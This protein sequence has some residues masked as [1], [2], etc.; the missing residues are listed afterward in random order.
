VK[1]KKYISGKAINKLMNDKNKDLTMFNKIKKLVDAE[2]YKDA[3][4]MY[5]KELKKDP[6]HGLLKE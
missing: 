1:A 4:K 3:E 2:Q 5:L 6:S